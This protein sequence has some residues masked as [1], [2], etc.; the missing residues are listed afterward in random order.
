MENGLDLRKAVIAGVALLVLI[1]VGSYLIFFRDDSGNEGDGNGSGVDNRSPVADSGQDITVLPGEVFYLNGSGSFDI[2]G[3]LLSYFWD[4]D[5]GTDTNNDGF[6]DNDRNREGANISYSYPVTG[7]TVEYI[8]TLNVSDGELWDK[9]TVRVTVLEEGPGDEAPEVEMSCRYQA[10]PVGLP[11]SPQ[12][13]LTVNSVSRNESFLDFIYKLES[14]DG[15]IIR[16][17]AVLEL[18]NLSAEE[19]IR[20]IDTP[21]LGEIDEND[22]FSLKENDHIVEGCWFHLFYLYE[23]EPSGS[24]ELTK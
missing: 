13:I 21:I 2:D 15:E 4:M 6:F 3:D 5:I 19:E 24:V 17:G 10:P 20:Y 9:S 18:I 1:S 16:Q 12:F 22:I 23:R 11:G 14:P 8:V 7:E